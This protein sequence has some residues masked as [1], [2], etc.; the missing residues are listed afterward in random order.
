[1]NR[2]IPKRRCAYL[3]TTVRNVEA[4]QNVVLGEGIDSC[5][6][7]KQRL[8]PA[9]CTERDRRFTWVNTLKRTSIIVSTC[10]PNRTVHHIKFFILRRWWR[11]AS[12]NRRSFPCG[13]VN[14]LDLVIAV[15]VDTDEVIDDDWLRVA[16]D[17]AIEQSNKLNAAVVSVDPVEGCGAGVVGP[18]HRQI[19][20]VWVG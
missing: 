11:N 12:G 16:V 3:R 13:S 10:V 1:M 19:D 9:V 6:G 15:V 5:W 18:L 14:A 7:E 2:C 4:R 20:H 17:G 8:V